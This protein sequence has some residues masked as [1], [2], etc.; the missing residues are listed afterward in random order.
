MCTEDK[1]QQVINSINIRLGIVPANQEQF[2]KLFGLADLAVAL[3]C[4]LSFRLKTG[5]VK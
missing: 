3:G 5:A 1:V 2:S 4:K